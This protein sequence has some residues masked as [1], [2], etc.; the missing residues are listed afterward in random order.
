VLYPEVAFRLVRFRHRPVSSPISSFR[1]ISVWMTT[2]SG[3]LRP[4]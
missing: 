1:S 4:A 3:L 2:G